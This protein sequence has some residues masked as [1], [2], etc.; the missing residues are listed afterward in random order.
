MKEYYELF[1][2]KVGIKYD[3]YYNKNYRRFV[4]LAWKIFAGNYEGEVNEG[5]C[6]ALQKI[7][8][9]DNTK[10]K[11]DTWIF[12]IIK[13]LIIKTIRKNKHDYYYE[14]CFEDNDFEYQ[15]IYDDDQEAKDYEEQVQKDYN[16]M[17][18]C[19]ND[20]PNKFKEVIT[21]RELQG[22]DYEL[23]AEKHNISLQLVK[24]RI[25]KGREILIKK[26]NHKKYMKIEKKTF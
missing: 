20:L 25:K 15:I 26:Y 8:T 24:N 6:D 9:Y 11:V 22:W 14:D 1:Y 12:S 10:S 18:E 17:L 19:I 7:K 5:M 23:I 3:D 4:F 16:I 21:A 13:N 2:E